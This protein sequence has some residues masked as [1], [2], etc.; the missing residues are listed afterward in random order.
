M[1]EIDYLQ[2]DSFDASERLEEPV[3]ENRAGFG[4]G[5]GVAALI[6]AGYGALATESENYPSIAGESPSL[7]SYIS[8][9]LE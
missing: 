2:D 3:H 5:I 7:S 8:D 1:D 6:A 4:A 9:I